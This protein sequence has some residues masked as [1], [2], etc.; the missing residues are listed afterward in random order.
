MCEFGSTM[1]SVAASRNVMVTLGS[2]EN[3]FVGTAEFVRN[4]WHFDL[5]NNTPLI[6]LGKG[7]GLSDQV[8]KNIY[9]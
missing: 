2:L 8:K 5:L 4:E 7:H 9:I 1:S 3:H 6:E